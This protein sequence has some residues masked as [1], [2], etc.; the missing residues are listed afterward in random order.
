MARYDG[1]H[2]AGPIVFFAAI[3]A[4]LCHLLALPFWLVGLMTPAGLMLLVFAA[5]LRS[6]LGIR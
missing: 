3:S 1:P 6:A 2:Y 4:L 5:W